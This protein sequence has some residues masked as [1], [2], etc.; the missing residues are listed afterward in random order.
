LQGP[1]ISCEC[2]DCFGIAFTSSLSQLIK[3]GV[4]KLLQFLDCFFVA[5]LSLLGSLSLLILNV[6]GS[7]LFSIGGLPCSVNSLVKLLKLLLR[8]LITGFINL[9]DLSCKV[10]YLLLCL[11]LLVALD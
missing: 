2:I 8:F 3:L 11:K 6:I 4:V 5:C 9:L 1:L 10:L 7:I